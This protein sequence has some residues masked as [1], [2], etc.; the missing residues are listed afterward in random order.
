MPNINIPG[1]PDPYSGYISP[2]ITSIDGD[3]NEEFYIENEAN[4]EDPSSDENSFFSIEEYLIDLS[5]SLD[6]SDDYKSA[7]FVDFILRKAGSLDDINY[8][9]AF[10]DL[11]LKINNSDLDM[12]NEIIKNMS[13]RFSRIINAKVASGSSIDDA[14][15]AAYKRCLSILNSK[16]S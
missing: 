2:D 4:D 16:M 7:D 15:R 8:S 6:N 12:R 11:L 10:N 5:N 13:I 3:E 14:K 1:P 9:D